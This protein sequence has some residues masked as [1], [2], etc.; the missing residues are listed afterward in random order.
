[1]IRRSVIGAAFT[2]ITVAS[3]GVPV[4]PEA[5]ELPTAAD[6]E[7][8]IASTTTTINMQPPNSSQPPAARGVILYFIR[9]EGLTGRPA[10]VFSEYSITT[11]LQLLV[12][13]PNVSD[14]GN[15]R[16]GLGQRSDLIERAEVVDRMATVD[17]PASLSD[18][19]GAEQVLI[20]GQ[21]TLTLV[22]NLNIDGV[23]FRQNG[24]QVVVPGADGQPITGAVG[25]ADYIA[26]VTKQ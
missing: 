18:L 14:L 19:P 10:I 17:L 26:L 16:S 21:I 8:Q 7:V 5:V 20:L 24:Q 6:F 13:G 15:L 2:V 9:G 12:D 25:R 11:L 22:S 4:D 3:C 1:M 23:M